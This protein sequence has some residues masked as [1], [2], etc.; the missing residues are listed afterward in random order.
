MFRKTVW[1]GGWAIVV[2]AA[3]AC[4]YCAVV[5]FETVPFGM[6]VIP[7]VVPSI[8]LFLVLE[9]VCPTRLPKYLGFLLPMLL[10]VGWGSFE[11]WSLRRQEMVEGLSDGSAD[12][13]SYFLECYGVGFCS[14]LAFLLLLGRRAVQRDAREA[15]K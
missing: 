15:G 11:I 14:A 4:T 3:G 6:F 5:S 2:A 9:R 7:L 13:T 12:F 10:I 8:L 1:R